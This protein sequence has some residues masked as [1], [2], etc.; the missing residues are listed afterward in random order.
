MIKN[1]KE[2]A[3]DTLP[4]SKVI[5]KTIAA[6]KDNGINAIIVETKEE[7]KEKVLSLIPEGSEVLNMTSVTLDSIGLPEIINNSGKYNSVRNKLNSLD[8][9]TKKLEQKKLGS[10]PEYTIGSV[11]AITEDGKVVVVSNTGSQL[12]AYVYGGAKIIWVAGAQKIVKKLDEAMKRIYDYILPLE[13]ARINKAYNI[14]I[15]SNVSKVFI[16]NKEIDKDRIHLIIVRE[17][18]GF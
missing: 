18:L 4:D 9:N 14:S 10:A 15:G 3:A 7:A 12:P 8:R 2:T 1:K 11:H 17:K 13:S 5:Q 16:L 6:L